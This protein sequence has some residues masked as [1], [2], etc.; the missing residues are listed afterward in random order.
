MTLCILP[1]DASPE[2]L[3][4]VPAGAGGAARIAAGGTN[5]EDYVGKRKNEYEYEYTNA[6]N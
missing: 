4:A 5:T 6:H 2:E 3:L 1:S